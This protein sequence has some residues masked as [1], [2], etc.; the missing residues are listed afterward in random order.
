MASQQATPPPE[1]LTHVQGLARH[2]GVSPN[3]TC[4]EI[5]LRFLQIKE[6]QGASTPLPKDLKGSSSPL[7]VSTS[8]ISS[9]PDRLVIDE[10]REPDMTTGNTQITPDVGT[11]SVQPNP[12]AP[13]PSLVPEETG[14][15][16]GTNPN[17]GTQSPEI[18]QMISNALS[19]GN[20]NPSPQRPTTSPALNPGTTAN[21]GTGADPVRRALSFP[22]DDDVDA[23]NGYQYVS[24]GKRKKQ[25]TAFEDNLE[26]EDTTT[27]QQPMTGFMLITFS[28][29]NN[30]F[31]NTNLTRRISKA[32]YDHLGQTVQA[33][34]ENT[35]IAFRVPQHLY[36]K[37]R[38]FINQSSTLP[39]LKEVKKTR[40][41]AGK[42]RE[43][44]NSQTSRDSKTTF[45]KGI[46]ET[47]G[48]NET[49]FRDTFDFGQNH[50]TSFQPIF[51]KFGRSTG[52]SIL[53]F[54]T[55]L[56]PLFIEGHDQVKAIKPMY[57]TPVRCNK[58]QE[59]GH[60]DTKC[61]NTHFRCTNC[62]GNH[63]RKDC[64]VDFRRTPFRCYNC[65]D[66]HTANHPMCPAWIRYK[67]EI[68]F[69]NRTITQEWE[70]RKQ[71]YYNNKG[72]NATANP[73]AAPTTQN[74]GQ[75]YAQALSPKDNP[76]K[77]DSAPPKVT[78]PTHVNTD[79][80]P[81]LQLPKNAVNVPPPNKNFIHIKDIALIFKH[82]LSSNTLA[83]L[84]N[85]QPDKRDNYIEHL[86]ASPFLFVG[87][88]ET[89]IVIDPDT[90]YDMPK[91][92]NKQTST[93]AQNTTQMQQPPPQQAPP[94]AKERKVL[95]LP[96]SG[97]QPQDPP[98]T[99]EQNPTNEPPPAPEPTAI[100]AT[101]ETYSQIFHR[102]IT[103]MC[104]ENKHDTKQQHKHAQR[105]PPKMTHKTPKKP[106]QPRNISMTPHQYQGHRNR[107]P[108]QK[109]L[110][111]F[112]T[113]DLPGAK[114]TPPMLTR[115]KVENRGFYMY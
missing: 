3:G 79:T 33:L 64:N 110:H 88:Q 4:N 13:T 69:K 37:A 95:R 11:S 108:K 42:S 103:R 73:Q 74:K 10:S 21:P 22:A 59:F 43:N 85:M 84:Q 67:E 65:N 41:Q 96:L 106:R 51:N 20:P 58:C 102:N 93:T 5:G 49:Q 38:Q 45:S 83:R 15:K 50:I 98:P 94:L 66:N 77:Q 14:L 72:N 109:H 53:T 90:T 8:S 91:C 71:A 115:G 9:S 54:D 111:N 39:T 70:T 105:P 86:V 80:L 16:P 52:R 47:N 44:Q 46:V 76:P 23:D 78:P 28:L 40:I 18:I 82:L 32:F 29:F 89:P 1:F 101:E 19:P 2:E 92:E 68:M 55:S 113:L 56:P 81:D 87:T 31:I 24:Y 114:V 34:T 25:Q 17:P 57:Y 36:S 97:T 104:D 7:D 12:P 112:R 60:R 75:T 107:L 27:S 26:E 99:T 63:L 62:S 61:R 30:G 48:A 6:Q 100:K 35:E